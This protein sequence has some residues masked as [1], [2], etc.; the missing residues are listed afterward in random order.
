MNLEELES[1]KDLN[2]LDL[3]YKIIDIA[4]ERI[5]D[6]ES[7]IAEYLW[8]VS[9]VRVRQSMQDIK[10]ISD[11]IRNN[12]QVRKEK[13]DT[14]ILEKAIQKEKQYLIERKAKN[15]EKKKLR[16]ERINERQWPKRK[17]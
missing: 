12:I 13:T 17:K 1:L 10:L 11:I 3:L 16:L 15:A 4:Q 6:T 9:G 2:E 8:K 14:K 5:L 7:V